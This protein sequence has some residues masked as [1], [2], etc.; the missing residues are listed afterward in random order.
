MKNTNIITTANLPQ[1]ANAEQHSQMNNV[2]EILNKN[3][4]ALHLENMVASSDRYTLTIKAIYTGG[5]S[6][7]PQA[8]ELTFIA[9]SKSHLGCSYNINL[10]C[11]HMD[12][13]VETSKLRAS[14]QELIEKAVRPANW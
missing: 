12:E 3:A 10:P 11:R 1:L 5:K 2:A 7:A 8:L 6:I 4:E 14:M 13:F 9:G